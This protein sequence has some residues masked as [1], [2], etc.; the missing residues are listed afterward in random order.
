MLRRGF[1]GGGVDESGNKVRHLF[2][3][4]GVG[5]V[6]WFEGNGCL[7]DNAVVLSQ[8]KVAT[9]NRKHLSD[10]GWLFLII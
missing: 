1:C 9:V 5:G 10:T 4:E 2:D 7:L 8:G 6:D 3:R